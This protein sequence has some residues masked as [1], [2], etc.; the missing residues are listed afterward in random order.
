[1]E[2]ALN[3][4]NANFG[5]YPYSRYSFVQAGDG[6]ME[7]PMATLITGNRPL[8]SLVG[9]AVHEF[10]HSWYYGVL[11]FNESLYYWMDE[12]FTN[13]AELRVM[14]H[15]RAKGLIP[16]ETAE[17]PFEGDLQKLLHCCHSWH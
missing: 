8:V 11:G 14:E 16:G 3:Y 12:G 9:V 1:M 15:L 6:G 10:L 4:S 2:E 17:F 5:V 13:Y 7:Y